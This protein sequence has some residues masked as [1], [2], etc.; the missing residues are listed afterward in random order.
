MTKGK[1]RLSSILTVTLAVF[2][3]IAAPIVGYLFLFFG[4]AML[5]LPQPTGLSANLAL[6][7]MWS[8]LIM[9]IILLFFAYCNFKCKVTE[10]EVE[11]NECFSSA[12]QR[13]KII[14]AIVVDFFLSVIFLSFAIS[15][16]VMK[17]MSAAVP[18]ITFFVG[19]LLLII[20]V[21]A[22]IC[23]IPM[24]KLPI[25]PQNYGLN[26]E[27]VSITQHTYIQYKDNRL[28]YNLSDYVNVVLRYLLT[29]CWAAALFLTLN[30]ILIARDE[31]S[32]NLNLESYPYLY[33]DKNIV[34][35]VTRFAILLAIIAAVGFLFFAVCAKCHSKTLA[36]IEKTAKYRGYF[37]SE[38]IRR[39]IKRIMSVDI[40]VAILLPIFLIC[41][42]FLLLDKSF[43]F[44]YL[45]VGI[46]TEVAAIIS[47][48]C[49]DA[50]V[51]LPVIP[52]SPYNSIP[53]NYPVYPWGMR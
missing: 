10:R 32:G 12:K 44:M 21:V 52:P 5:S 8:S 19:C 15:L 7:F 18:V 36:E 11:L 40:L 23:K 24:L 51:K 31:W 4:I 47:A 37:E 42:G 50:V 34:F 1:W 13:N 20:S 38:E 6:F 22:A 49:K 46:A 45:L 35:I 16:L 29:V 43:L 41:L 9:P 2:L 25:I 3:I 17:I 39:R 30:C 33:A 27:Q 53:N 28:T 26:G 48:A 14:V